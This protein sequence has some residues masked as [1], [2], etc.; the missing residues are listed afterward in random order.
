MLPWIN[1]NNLNRLISGSAK[2][3]CKSLKNN[4]QI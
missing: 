2:R 4:N 3:W 1:L